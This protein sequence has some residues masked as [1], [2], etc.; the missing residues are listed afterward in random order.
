MHVCVCMYVLSC[1]CR[2][3]PCMHVC[4]SLHTL[5][6]ACLCRTGSELA[7]RLGLLGL[8]SEVLQSTKHCQVLGL[9]G[10]CTAAMADR[11]VAWKALET[12]FGSKV[13]GSETKTYQIKI[14][15]ICGLSDRLTGSP[16]S[17]YVF[18]CLRAAFLWLQFYSTCCIVHRLSR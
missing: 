9:L 3:Y 5:I 11:D 17:T 6:P 1:E 14:F 10:L 13:R 4:A 15:R 2:R 8:R 16:E 12:L 7:R 18:H